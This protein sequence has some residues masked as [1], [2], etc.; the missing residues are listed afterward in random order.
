MTTQ[1]EEN[2]AVRTNVAQDNP[3]VPWYELD[4]NRRHFETAN[5]TFPFFDGMCDDENNDYV[6]VVKWSMSLPPCDT[7]I[8]MS[9]GMKAMA[10]LVTKTRLTQ[11]QTSFRTQYRCKLLRGSSCC[12]IPLFFLDTDTAPCLISVAYTRDIRRTTDSPAVAR[13]MELSKDE[14]AYEFYFKNFLRFVIPPLAFKNC[15]KQGPTSLSSNVDRMATSID[16]ARGGKAMVTFITEE[17]ETL[18]LFFLDNYSDVW[19]AQLTQKENT[20]TDVFPKY[21]TGKKNTLLAQKQK[22]VKIAK[23]HRLSNEGTARWNELYKKVTADRKVIEREAWEQTLLNDM[24]TEATNGKK[25]PRAAVAQVAPPTT[26]RLFRKP[27]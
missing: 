9:E 16:G 13:I 20:V 24:T 22:G 21:T 15:I 8:V 26:R 3:L 11:L 17:E 27:F 10:L 18:G 4:Q 14:D 6:E 19:Q 7:T 23:G 5:R 1:N 12:T 25:R 2:T